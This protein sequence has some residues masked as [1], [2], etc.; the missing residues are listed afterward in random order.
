MKN[1][2]GTVEWIFEKNFSENFAMTSYRDLYSKVL[3]PEVVIQYLNKNPTIKAFS[4]Q[5]IR[6]PFPENSTF[7]FIPLICIRDPVDR[8]FSVYSYFKRNRGKSHDSE[9]AKNCDVKEYIRWSL[10]E[11]KNNIIK[12]SQNQFLSAKSSRFFNKGSASF[13][14]IRTSLL[15]VVDR[16]DESMVVIEDKLQSIFGDIDFSYVKQHVSSERNGTESER[17]E[18]ERREIGD[19][20]MNELI[21]NNDRDFELYQLANNELDSRIND[22]ESFEEKLSEFRDRC[23]RMARTEMKVKNKRELFYSVEDKELIEKVR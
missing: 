20:L 17:L 15:V 22:I 11:S 18:E 10:Y 7:E 14:L 3:P 5:N 23:K 9:K 1:A 6:P 21:K 4:S 12:N 8:A 19:E 13:N 2:G 16:F